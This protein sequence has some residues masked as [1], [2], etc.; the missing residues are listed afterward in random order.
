MLVRRYNVSMKTFPVTEY[1]ATPE[2]VAALE[3]AVDD[4]Y[5]R[6]RRSGKLKGVLV[7]ELRALLEEALSS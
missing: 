4:R 3:K 1:G 6:L 2:R 7:A 5:R